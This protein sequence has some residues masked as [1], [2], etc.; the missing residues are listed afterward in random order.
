MTRR[1]RLAAGLLI[2]NAA[3]VH[4]QTDSANMLD[5]LAGLINRGKLN[6]EVNLQPGSAAITPQ[7]ILQTI[8][9][10]KATLSVEA[11]QGRVKCVDVEV[12]GGTLLIAGKGLRPSLSI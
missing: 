2:L 6:V 1:V 8:G 10:P 11:D 12:T 9:S 5:Q 3:A 4:A 7:W